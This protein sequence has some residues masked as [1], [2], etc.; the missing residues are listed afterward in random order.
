[1]NFRVTCWVNPRSG[2]ELAEA[3]KAKE[4]CLKIFDLSSNSR[5]KTV[6]KQADKDGMILKDFRFQVDHDISVKEL[7]PTILQNYPEAEISSW[8]RV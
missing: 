8:D 7:M 3:N 2:F 5:A 4:I 6:F 1:M